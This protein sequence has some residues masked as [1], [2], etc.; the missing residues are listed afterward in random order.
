MI[1]HDATSKEALSKE[2]EVVNASL[3]TLEKKPN[4]SYTMLEDKQQSSMQSEDGFQ[5]IE[6]NMWKVYY[7]IALVSKYLINLE[8]K[9]Q[10]SQRQLEEM[11]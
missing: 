4:I 2:M 8:H 6:L 9:I 3:L 1:E 5:D 11:H 10:A 7:D